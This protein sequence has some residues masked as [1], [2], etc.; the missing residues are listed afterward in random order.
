MTGECGRSG[1]VGDIGAQFVCAD[2]TSQRRHPTGCC[3]EGPRREAG[4]VGLHGPPL[5]SGTVMPRVVGCKHWV[6][7][8]PERGDWPEAGV[9]DVRPLWP[10]HRGGQHV[11]VSALTSAPTHSP[12]PAGLVGRPGGCCSELGLGVPCS[13]CG[14]GTKGSHPQVSGVSFFHLQSRHVLLCEC[15][16][17]S[18]AKVWVS[19]RTP[20]FRWNG[21]EQQ[22]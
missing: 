18:Q 13:A 17:F 15:T 7:P 9:A 3:T 4:C 5:N 21:T 2:F 16:F 14:G 20:G 8:L 10:D 1:P 22:P 12:R 6:S 19:V 11:V